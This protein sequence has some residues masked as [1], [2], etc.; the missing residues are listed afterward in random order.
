MIFNDFLRESDFIHLENLIHNENFSWYKKS[1]TSYVKNDPAFNNDGCYFNHSLFNNGNITSEAFYFAQPIL[2]KLKIQT[3]LRVQINLYPKTFFKKKHGW[4]I[5]YEF[6]HKGL[7]LA[8]NTNNGKTITKKKSYKSIRNRAFI[9]EPHL[10]H[11]STTCT[12]KEFRSNI[13]IN[14]V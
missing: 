1:G 4:H 7:L 13:I 11:R 6:P 5:D 10:P 8:L 9:F 12:D 2:N 14:Y 3:L